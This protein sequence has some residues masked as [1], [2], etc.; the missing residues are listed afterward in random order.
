[1]IPTLHATCA[2]LIVFCAILQVHDMPQ[3]GL[4]A[5]PYIFLAVGALASGMEPYFTDRHLTL[6]RE[7]FMIG[8][9]IFF[10][11]RRFTDDWKNS[12]HC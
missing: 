6:P 3:R 12:T 8:S 2:M 4:R 10:M 11:T 5:I 7:L 1:M 9:T